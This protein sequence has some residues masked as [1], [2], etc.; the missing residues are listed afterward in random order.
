MERRDIYVTLVLFTIL[1]VLS[2]VSSDLTIKAKD[3][4]VKRM[5]EIKLPHK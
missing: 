1:V 3:D 2:I 5:T 4:H